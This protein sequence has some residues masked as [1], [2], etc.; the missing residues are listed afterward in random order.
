ML[1]EPVQVQWHRKG[2]VTPQIISYYNGQ[3]DKQHI[4]RVRS[5]YQLLRFHHGRMRPC[6]SVT[7]N[8]INDKWNLINSHGIEAKSRCGSS[9]RWK[10]QATMPIIFL[11][12]GDSLNAYKHITLNMV[13]AADSTCKSPLLHLTTRFHHGRNWL[14]GRQSLERY[15]RR[16]LNSQKLVALPSW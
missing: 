14:Y 10:E 1:L 11:W 2:K 15:N 3:G 5:W 8:K 9:E 16:R 6:M 4:A 13:A 12:Q 7:T